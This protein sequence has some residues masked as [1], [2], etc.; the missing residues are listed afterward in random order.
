MT[1]DN[2]SFL[3]SVTLSLN[4]KIIGKNNTRP[5]K[6]RKHSDTLNWK[7]INFPPT[8]EDYKQFE[9]D[10]KDVKLNILEIKSDEKEID[11]IYKSNFDDRKQ[12]KYIIVRKKTL[13]ICKRFRFSFE[14]FIIRIRIR[15]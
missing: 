11:Y 1:K 9:I 4:H 6:I 10:N 2:K 8:S 5:N 14:L 15:I 13:Y 12:S 7:N 3:D